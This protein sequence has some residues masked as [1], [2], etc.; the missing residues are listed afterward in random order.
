[1][2][3]HHGRKRASQRG[4][5]GDLIKLIRSYG[6]FEGDRQILD[7]HEIAACL[8][9]VARFRAKLLKLLDKGGGI[10][11]FREDDALITVFSPD[12]Y[13]RP[14]RSQRARRLRLA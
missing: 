9:A 14:R 1:M 12:T 10:A 6:T 11:V 8:E 4:Y 5:T 13:R 2:D 7:R 3:T